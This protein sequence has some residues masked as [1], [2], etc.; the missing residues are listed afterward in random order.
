MYTVYGIK[1]CNTVKK[2]LD[3]LNQHKIPYQFHDYK[4]EGITKKKLSEWAKQLGW[5]P[6]INKKGTTWRGLDEATKA[7]ITNQAAGLALAQEK[8]SVIK[9]P[10]IE[11]EGQVVTLGFDE[12]AYA[13]IRWKK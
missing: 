1:N 13:D 11:Q 7:G 6:L 8:T 10:I 12:T 9:R 3:F 4:K 2:A 5:E